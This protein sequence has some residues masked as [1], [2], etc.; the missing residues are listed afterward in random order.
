M[1]NQIDDAGEATQEDSVDQHLCVPNDEENQHEGVERARPF[2]EVAVV[3]GRVEDDVPVN[4]PSEE[5]SVNY[6]ETYQSE[7]WFYPKTM[8]NDDNLQEVRNSSDS[9]N[10]K[11]DNAPGKNRDSAHSISAEV[12]NHC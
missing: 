12:C 6:Q 1:Q 8:S 7:Y 5:E 2:L 11:V 4:Q 9:K 10:D 3:L